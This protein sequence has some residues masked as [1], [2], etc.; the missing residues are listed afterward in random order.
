MVE[1]IG[2][3]IL[4]GCFLACLVNLVCAVLKYERI[5]CTLLSH[6]VKAKGVDVD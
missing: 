5:R 4:G 6:I 3:A 2:I 1:R